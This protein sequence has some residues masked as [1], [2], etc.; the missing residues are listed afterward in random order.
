[1]RERAPKGPVVVAVPRRR[2]MEF[3]GRDLGTVA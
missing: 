2:V 3:P 1:L